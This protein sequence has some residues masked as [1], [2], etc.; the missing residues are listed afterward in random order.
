METWHDIIGGPT[1][2]DAICDRIVYNA[3][4][5]T[6]KGDGSIRKII[7]KDIFRPDIGLNTYK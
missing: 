7:K 3:H 6:L 2:A 4:K 5:I 1:F